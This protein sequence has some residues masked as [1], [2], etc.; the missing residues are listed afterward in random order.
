MTNILKRWD[1]WLFILSLALFS[2][3]AALD[4]WAS[5]LFYDGQ[6]FFLGRTLFFYSV[7]ELFGYLPYLLVPLLLFLAG[8][9]LW[10]YKDG[11]DPF[12]RKIFLFLFLSLVI[13]PG[14]LVNAVFKNNSVG[15]ARPSQIVE[16]G[17][18]EQ[19]TPAW[20]YSGAC[21]TNCSFVSGHASMGFYFIALGWLLRRQRWFWIGFGIGSLV[22]LTRIVQGGHFLS[23]TVFAFWVVYGTNL[24]LAQLMKL[25]SPFARQ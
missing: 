7:Y 13:G 21:E 23:D 18:Q 16:F 19:F 1:L 11:S 8:W 22:G 9:A 14:I 17:G 24:V 20:V 25:P 10:R 12:K 6:Q 5:N 4:I 15:R 3:F 2:V